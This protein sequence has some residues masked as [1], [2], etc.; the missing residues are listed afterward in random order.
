MPTISLALSRRVRSL[1]CSAG[2]LLSAIL[3]SGATCRGGGGGGGGGQAA[4]PVFTSLEVPSAGSW[5]TATASGGVFPVLPL[6]GRGV[7]IHFTAPLGSTYGVTFVEPDGTRTAVA[8]NSGTPAPP[9]AGYFQILATT[10]A[11]PPAWTM[12]VRAPQGLQSPENYQIWVV[13]LGGAARVTESGPMIVDLDPRPRFTVTVRVE[14]GGL[15]TSNPPGITCGTS[16][17]G[18]AQTNCLFD[19]APGGTVSLLPNSNDGARFVGFTGNCQGRQVCTL[20]L[21]GSP[22]SAT[23]LFEA[24]TM[25]TTL[26]TCPVAPQLPG[27]RWI[28]R[29]NCA[30]GQI[31][32][33]PG[34]TLQCDARGYFCCEPSNGPSSPRCP[35]GGDETEPDC[36]VHQPRGL[37]RQP[38]G[39]YE[40]D[41]FP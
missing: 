9:A 23:A 34:I 38:G 40:V 8:E 25:S 39:C 30:T 32:Y 28:D 26:P 21:S 7:R 10:A 4:A 2:L 27:L 36:M 33:H 12:Y 15:V 37:L 35:G 14:G 22:A 31:G 18:R 20:A 11:S 5:T 6:P 24:D 3:S 19:F 16:K 29:P 1:L 13:N 41:S 17:Q